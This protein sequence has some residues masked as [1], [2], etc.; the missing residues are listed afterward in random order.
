[1]TRFGKTAADFLYHVKPYPPVLPRLY[2]S[3]R[4]VKAFF[5]GML[6]T[7]AE[8]VDKFPLDR[9]PFRCYI[10]PMSKNHNDPQASDSTPRPR[11]EDAPCCGCCPSSREAYYGRNLFATDGGWPGDGSGMDDLA[12]YNQMEGDDY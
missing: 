6:K 12:D 7:R 1:L 4:D 11:C 3:V 8:I 10:I 5:L 9:C 2:Y